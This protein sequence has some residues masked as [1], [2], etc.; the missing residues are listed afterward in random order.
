VGVRT[1][2]EILG[3]RSHVD[4]LDPKP[5]DSKRPFL[6]SRDCFEVEL[7]LPPEPAA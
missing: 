4:D 3:A 7:A 6:F 5:D 2:P 1:N